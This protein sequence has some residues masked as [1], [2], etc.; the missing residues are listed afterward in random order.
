MIEILIPE[1]GRASIKCSIECNARQIHQSIYTSVYPKSNESISATAFY[2]S[3]CILS[4]STDVGATTSSYF[5]FSFFFVEFL[6][7]VFQMTNGIVLYR[8]VCLIQSKSFGRALIICFQNTPTTLQA[9]GATNVSLEMPSTSQPIVQ[10]MPDS[11]PKMASILKLPAVFA[12][13]MRFFIFFFYIS[14]MNRNF[15]K[16]CVTRNRL[17]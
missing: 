10:R 17:I 11:L 6:F 8:C 14:M 16:V 7:L 5:E 3:K 15:L 2:Q 13:P 12:P 1:D 4:I 9:S